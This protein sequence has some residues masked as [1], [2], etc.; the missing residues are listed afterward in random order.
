M[1][2]VRTQIETRLA[3]CKFGR[4]SRKLNKER[5]GVRNIAKCNKCGGI[6]ES[7]HVHDFR[8]CPCGSISVDG[9][10]EYIRRCGDPEDFDREFDIAHGFMPQERKEPERV[11]PET[12]DMGTLVAL[13]WEWFEK[14]GLKDPVMQ[15]VKVQE[16][17][18]ELASEIARGHR[19]SPELEDALGDVMVTIIGMC[20]HLHYHPAHALGTAYNTIKNRTGKVVEGSF[21]KDER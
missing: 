14:K 8:T 16:E 7:H 6:I 17:V 20:H 11:E 15:M 4:I 5:S 2:H 12:Y 9:G 19:Q 21:V 1:K 3:G 18:G 13:V 10:Q